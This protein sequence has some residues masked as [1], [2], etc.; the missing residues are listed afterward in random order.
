VAD[1]L[2]HHGGQEGL[3]GANDSPTTISGNEIFANNVEGFNQSWDAGG[4]K[5]SDPVDLVVNGNEIHH[6]T[7]GFWTD[8]GGRNVVFT[9]NVV[10][11]N[12]GAGV[13]FEITDGI[14]AHGNVLHNN[15][16]GAVHDPAGEPAFK[17]VSVRDAEIYDNVLAWNE[18]SIVVA[19]A[20]RDNGVG[21]TDP[22]FDGV[23][24]VRVHHNDIVVSDGPGETG[25]TH[26]ALAWQKNG[27]V[28]RSVCDQ[29]GT[30]CLDEPD[31]NNRGFDNRYWYPNP[32]GPSPRFAWGPDLITL[33]RFNRTDGE[34]R[35]RYL[36]DA[37][38][39]RLL[40]AMDVPADPRPIL[41]EQNLF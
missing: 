15:G 13:H 36:S 28:T 35:G 27:D 8:G 12:L 14:A 19:N 11:H 16:W 4:V 18:D 26:Y 7:K 25:R 10:H 37:E 32:E 30:T 9:S 24:D 40:T 6:N 20:V 22:R 21:A 34:E 1:N 29:R 23:H 31:A 41:D 38:K 17:L 39:A 33:A 2:I 5:I 3:A